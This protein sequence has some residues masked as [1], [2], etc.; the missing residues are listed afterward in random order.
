MRSIIGLHR[1]EADITRST[2]R[3]KEAGL[4]EDRISIFTQES[5]IRKLLGCDPI[6][7]VSRFAAWGVSIGIAAYVL[8]ALL[9]SLCQCNLF[10][11]EQV[12]GVGTFL[13]G[14]LAG[15]FIGGFL[16]CLVGAAEFEKDS[17]L[18]VRCPN[19]WKDNRHPGY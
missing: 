17:H 19:G 13:G 4:P 14:I 8:P 6:C 7:V 5:A 12:Y 2:Q 1:D 18:Y 15:A 11:F 3:L 16:G 9:A 10:H